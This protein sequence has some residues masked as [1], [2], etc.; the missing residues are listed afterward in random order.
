M[1][2]LTL[3][4]ED[5]ASAAP[6]IA[7]N[8]LGYST[9]QLAIPA[10]TAGAYLID[11]LHMRTLKF[12]PMSASTPDDFLKACHG[13]LLCK[14]SLSLLHQR[15]TSCQKACQLLRIAALGDSRYDPPEKRRLLF[16][17]LEPA[18]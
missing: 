14:I 2:V 4:A 15:A 8:R 10:A 5:R 17:I 7:E 6:E 13:M 3:L 18:L 12:S 9:I 1:Q 16:I 11:M